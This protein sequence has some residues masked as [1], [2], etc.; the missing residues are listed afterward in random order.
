MC[1]EEGGYYAIKGFLFQYDKLILELLSTEDDTRLF[2]ERVQDIDYENY[3]LQVKHK[4]T[5]NFS[6]SKVRDP[7]IKLLDIFVSEQSKKFCLYAYFKDQ[8]PHVFK[9]EKIEELKKVLK[10]KDKEKTEALYAKYTDAVLEKFIQN[11]SLCFSEDFEKQFSTVLNKISLRMGVSND[12]AWIYHAIISDKLFKIV[13][14]KNS[15]ERYITFNELKSYVEECRSLTF[16]NKYK[17]IVGREQ[18]LKAIKKKYF[19]F[20]SPNINN[21]ERLFLIECKNIENTTVVRQIIDSVSSKYYKRGKSPAPYICLRNLDKNVLNDVKRGL[22]DD[23]QKFSD[24]T[25]FDGDCFRKEKLQME[26]DV[27][28]K[29]IF[30]ESID[31]FVVDF[32]EVYEFYIQKA[33]KLCVKSYKIKIQIESIDEIKSLI[34]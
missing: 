33:T 31:T 32:K 22:I 17:E 28:I 20:K 27:K 12:E 7:I 9:F 15:E 30:E 16:E 34:S 1:Q 26:Q 18:F 8:K 29:F 11:F 2:I 6:N 24:G 25:Y 19:T 5:A 3:V 10:Y 13:L 4:E 23:N 14:K 21:Y